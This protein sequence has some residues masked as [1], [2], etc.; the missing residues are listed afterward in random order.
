MCGVF[1]VKLKQHS[2]ELSMDFD[3]ATP[4]PLFLKFCFFFL[5][6][7][8]GHVCV[9]PIIVLLQNPSAP[10][11]WVIESKIHVSINYSKSSKS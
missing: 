10:K 4:E 9:F 1:K 11:L 2:P 7:K 3:K 5:L 6:F 8:G